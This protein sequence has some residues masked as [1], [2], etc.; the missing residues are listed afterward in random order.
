MDFQKTC[1]VLDIKF[2]LLPFI[3]CIYHPQR[4]RLKWWSS[5]H[6]WTLTFPHPSPKGLEREKRGKRREREFLA[7]SNFCRSREEKMWQHIAE[8][9]RPKWHT[10]FLSLRSPS[11]LHYTQRRLWSEDKKKVPKDPLLLSLIQTD[12]GYQF[13]YER[14]SLFFLTRPRMW[15]E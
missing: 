8:M 3:R 2:L 4:E 6:K 9:H 10:L 5:S 11:D 14:D 1:Q 7:E 13:V 12:G 15:L